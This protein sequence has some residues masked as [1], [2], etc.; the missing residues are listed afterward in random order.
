MTVERFRKLEAAMESG[1]WLELQERPDPKCKRCYGRGYE[2]YDVVTKR[3][4]LCQCV[5][6]DNLTPGKLKSKAELAAEFIEWS[7]QSSMEA[8]EK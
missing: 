8:S 6:K 1:N 2:G 7:I 4:L 5:S 3:Y